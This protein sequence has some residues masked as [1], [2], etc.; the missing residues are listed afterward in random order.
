MHDQCCVSVGYQRCSA[1]LRRAELAGVFYNN[2]YP[3]AMYIPNAY[4]MQ[5]HLVQMYY[6]NLGIVSLLFEWATYLVSN[7]K[8]T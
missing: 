6:R 2:Y 5:F 1:L 7:S 4:M 3:S 8:E